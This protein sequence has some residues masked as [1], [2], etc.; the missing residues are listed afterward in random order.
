MGP[1]L[2]GLCIFLATLIIAAI[3]IYVRAKNKKSTTH[4][5]VINES[6]SAKI[7]SAYQDFINRKMGLGDYVNKLYNE[8]DAFKMACRKLMSEHNG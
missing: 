4:I 2:T 6:D 1:F 5:V 3:A 7:E 8:K